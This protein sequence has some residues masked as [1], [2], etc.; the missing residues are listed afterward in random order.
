MMTMT[1]LEEATAVATTPGPTLLLAFELGER[2][3]KLGF[4]TGLGQ[5]PRV[6]QVP[7][8]ATDRVLE[9]IARAKVRFRVPTGAP[10][11]GES[12]IS[13]ALLN[14]PPTGH[15][16]PALI[17]LLC[18]T[19]HLPAPNRQT[20]VVFAEHS[21]PEDGAVQSVIRK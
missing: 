5:R 7:A 2:V 21:L 14:S 18:Q 20:D 12:L 16:A 13:S 1:R 15:S 8:R 6:R 3:W 4:T 11:G 9:E 17:T 10:V 19:E